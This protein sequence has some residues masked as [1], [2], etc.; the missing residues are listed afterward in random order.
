MPMPDNAMPD[1]D[2]LALR[3]LPFVP[4]FVFVL[5]LLIPLVAWPRTA[6]HT[7]FVPASALSSSIP[8]ATAATIDTSHDVVRLTTPTGALYAAYQNEGPLVASLTTHHVPVSY[9]GLSA[10]LPSL[11]WLLLLGTQVF[12]AL[13]AGAWLGLRLSRPRA[14][15]LDVALAFLGGMVM[16][17][18][19]IS[20]WASPGA[21][22]TELKSVSLLARFAALD[23]APAT[24]ILGIAG[25]YATLSVF[26]LWNDEDT[27]ATA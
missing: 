11:D 5:L 16:I 10:P 7:S 12:L 21:L 6:S 8:S 15:I 14:T 18:A 23:L 9:S 22:P 24:I 17:A 2:R 1:N 3:L 4:L 27:A 13:F 26:H 19:T 20:L 25:L